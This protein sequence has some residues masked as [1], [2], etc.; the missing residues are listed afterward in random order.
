MEVVRKLVATLRHE[1]N[2]PLGAVLGAAFL[3]KSDA[4]ASAEQ[5]E[6]AA[7]VEASG[8]RIKHVLNEMASATDLEE[9]QKGPESVFHVPGDP[10]WGAKGRTPSSRS[11]RGKK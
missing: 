10:A 2:N 6:A 4:S 11:E 5:K 8:A 1:I 9:V 3:L 7:L